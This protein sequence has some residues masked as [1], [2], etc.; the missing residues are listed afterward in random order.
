ME[1]E[2]LGDWDHTFTITMD[3]FVRVALM[4]LL[5]STEL[6]LE[7]RYN[8]N[9]GVLERKVIVFQFIYNQDLQGRFMGKRTE[10]WE[11]DPSTPEECKMDSVV[12]TWINRNPDGTPITY[13][14]SLCGN[15][16]EQD[17]SPEDT[18]DACS[19]M[20][21]RVM[22]DVDP[23]L[24]YTF[25]CWRF[26]DW[27]CQPNYA[28]LSR[29][30]I[31]HVGDWETI[32][33]VDDPLT[34]TP[35][36]NTSENS[37]TEYIFHQCFGDPLPPQHN[38]ETLETFTWVPPPVWGDNGSPHYECLDCN[39]EV[40]ECNPPPI[41]EKCSITENPPGIAV[42][43]HEIG[44]DWDEVRLEFTMSTSQSNDSCPELPYDP[45]DCQPKDETDGYPGT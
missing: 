16:E 45:L 26:L 18:T 10:E 38:G 12:N 11:A 1:G 14:C 30:Y 40:E 2:N 41:H 21:I 7:F 25:Y 20:P 31:R 8:C 3:G 36:F 23:E 5:S 28:Y 6:I 17:D 35:K 42:Q 22:H 44:D 4:E 19:V 15:C 33:A 43:V 13:G 9:T 27:M 37:N 34:F 29:N 32:Q 24:S 39:D